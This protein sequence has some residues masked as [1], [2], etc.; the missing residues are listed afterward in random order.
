MEEQK[1]NRRL[2]R[3]QNEEALK[4]PE[5]VETP[6]GDFDNVAGE[7]VSENVAQVTPRRRRARD[8]SDRV[9]RFVEDS[10]DEGMVS[11]E[12]SFRRVAEDDLPE[13]SELRRMPV[14]ESEASDDARSPEEG[15][16]NKKRSD[17]DLPERPGT[18]RM[19]VWTPE[20]ADEY[21][22]ETPEP[23]KM[24]VWTPSE[25]VRTSG[26]EEGGERIGN[27][28]KTPERVRTSGAEES[29]ERT[30][31][32]EERRERLAR[33][34]RR[35]TALILTMA[36]LTVIPR[37]GGDGR[38]KETVP[39]ETTQRITSEAPVAE[40]YGGNGFTIQGNE[41]GSETIVVDAPVKEET[42]ET[43]AEE[44]EAPEAVEEE[45]AEEVANEEAEAPEVAVEEEPASESA[46]ESTEEV[47]SEEST[48]APEDS[49][50]EAEAG[51]N[52][53]MDGMRFVEYTRAFDENGS[54]ILI[55]R[56]EMVG[57]LRGTENTYYDR[58]QEK[59]RSDGLGV[60]LVGETAAQK[61]E[62]LQQIIASQPE[63]AADYA[64][65]LEVKVF[66]SDEEQ[67]EYAKH[68]KEMEFEE[69]KE[70]VQPVL[71]E[72]HKRLDGATLENKN[73]YSLRTNGKELDR[74][75]TR[76]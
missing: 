7:E 73:G 66:G 39:S 61:M 2:R 43:I 68:L 34:F 26:A 4:E 51:E 45:A 8:I 64:C 9:S 42:E 67:Y 33:G 32:N 53:D 52:L 15:E 47:A 17:A 18:R 76:F 19:Q 16:K 37:D 72:F 3:I 59:L 29:S 50:E 48:E 49:V 56:Y 54:E 75:K 14:E 36:G 22:P 70:E 13:E 28:E 74:S 11:G 12:V 38:K 40:T 27:N 57:D 46:E 24:P 20:T 55:G 31:R 6:I 23:W 1:Y 60:E 10:K 71:D 35:A 5:P 30:K 63:I 58:E 21:K 69:Y 41:P 62:R 65:A 25:G 44:T